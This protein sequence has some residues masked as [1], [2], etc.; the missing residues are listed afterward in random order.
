MVEKLDTAQVISV[1]AAAYPNWGVNEAT[2]EVYHELLGDLDG[3]VVK[4][5]AKAWAMS[6]KWPPTVADLRSMSAEML[7]VTA[8][9]PEEAWGEVMQIAQVYGHRGARPEWSHPAISAAVSSMGFRDICLSERPD[10]V[11][12]QFLKVYE[13][14]RSRSERQTITSPSLSAGTQRIELGSVLKSLGAG[15]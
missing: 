5:A 12:G 10:V 8:P 15:N 11:R 9:A 13:G 6:E 14:Y 2:I 1:L 7:G 4:A 3:D